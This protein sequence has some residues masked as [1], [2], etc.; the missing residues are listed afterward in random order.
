MGESGAMMSCMGCG[1][2][3]RS[4]PKGRCPECG[5]AFDPADAKTYRGEL[6]NVN[7]RAVW[8]IIIFGLAWPIA[9]ILLSY[10]AW[11]CGYAELGRWPVESLDDPKGM[12]QPTRSIVHVALLLM[13]FS[14]CAL[15]ATLIFAIEPAVIIWERR[16]FFAAARVVLI[17]IAGWIS[18][19][20]FFLLAQSHI[21]GWML[22]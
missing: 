22:D 8:I 9:L 3:L 13:Y 4:L 16:S 14:P 5:R 7:P 2:D 19:V 12:G 17:A 15:L 21:V 11:W 20:G 18:L 6:R 1:Y 10:A